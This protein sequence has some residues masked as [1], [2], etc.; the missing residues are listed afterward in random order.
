[1]PGRRSVRRWGVVCVVLGSLPSAG[2]DARAQSNTALA[3]QLY[4]EGQK[5]MQAGRVDD[6]CAKFADSE[7][8][9]HALGTLINLAVC[10]EKQG[11]IA[12]AWGEF[13]D[14]AAQASKG[15]QRDREGF[16][17]GR[18]EALERRLQKLII[19]I[20]APVSGMVVKLDGQALPPSALGTAI[21]LDPGDHQ[22]D[23]DAPGKKTWRQTKL[24]LGPSAVLT[25]VQITFED[26][27]PATAA[28]KASSAG[29]SADAA[30]GAAG[31]EPSRA[32]PGNGG[33][34]VGLVLGGV[35]LVGVG[36]G[37]TML[38]LASSLSSRSDDEIHRG[39]VATGH[40]DHEAAV[41]DQTVGYVVGGLGIAALGVG[42][43]FF[44][45]S[46]GGPA[47]G[48]ARS[49]RVLPSVGPGYAGFAARGAF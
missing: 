18:A 22:L 13:T 14:A 26:D 39:D 15:G 17:R 25:R 43:Y 29:P 38:V 24:N 45:S 40:N 4:L 9:D 3:E 19:E 7:R 34:T 49:V 10:H 11:K 33:R 31:G 1:M 20:A 30:A 35:G 6:A 16:A 2:R 32:T 28:N 44:L 42:A 46:T 21:P 47:S 8:L 48:T 41:G 5:L 12:T 37:V 27:A 23:A 36:V